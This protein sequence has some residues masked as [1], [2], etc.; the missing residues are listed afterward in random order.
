MLSSCSP[1]RRGRRPVLC[2]LG[3]TMDFPAPLGPTMH[4]A[5][6]RSVLGTGD[7]SGWTRSKTT[8]CAAV[9][10]PRCQ[11][12]TR[13][14]PAR[15]ELCRCGISAQCCRNS[16]WCLVLG[17]PEIS[18]WYAG[19][20]KTFQAHKEAQSRA[21]AGQVGHSPLQNPSEC[22]VPPAPQGFLCETSG[23]HC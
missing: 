13:G 6:G 19:W 10:Q 12:N 9:S 2:A 23:L 1:G 11:V 18:R 15:I 21:S 3:R 7:T 20:S 16:L 4:R 17:P 5:V 14:L 22:R 8:P